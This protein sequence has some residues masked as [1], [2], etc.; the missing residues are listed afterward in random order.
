LELNGNLKGRENLEKFGTKK[1]VIITTRHAR[2]YKK[3]SRTFV[4]SKNQNL[5]FPRLSINGKKGIKKK[6]KHETIKIV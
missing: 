3:I 4:K 5:R 6:N 2:F 1:C